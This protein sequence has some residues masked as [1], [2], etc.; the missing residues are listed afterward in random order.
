MQLK[1]EK[2]DSEQVLQ[3]K[4]ALL[5]AFPSPA[6][7]KEMVRLGLDQNL[8][9]IATGENLSEVVLKLIENAEASGKVKELLT[10]ACNQEY[11]QPRNPDLMPFCEQLL[12]CEQLQQEQTTTKQSHRLLN[13]CNFDLNQLIDNC[14]GVLLGKKQGLV[15][16]AVPCNDDAFRSHFCERLKIALGRSNIQIKPLLSLNP[17]VISVEQAVHSIKKYKLDVQR[18]DIICPIRVEVD[19]KNKNKSYCDEFWQGICTA[20]PDNFEHRLIM[21]M[22]GSKNSIFPNNVKKLEPPQFKREH[23]YQWVVQMREILRW[24]EEMIDDWMETMMTDCLLSNPPNELLDIRGVYD[25]LDYSRDLLQRKLS[26]RAFLEEL[27]QRI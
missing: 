27:K 5:S 3:L 18:R 4:Q 22:V 7:L 17:L 1:L 16:L 6:K 20:F 11:G 25:H 24:E 13:P 12:Q 8:D 10:A 23:V 19:R 2:L 14:L 9:A 15:G 21:I 26:S